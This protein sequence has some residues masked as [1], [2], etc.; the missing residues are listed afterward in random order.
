MMGIRDHE[1]EGFLDQCIKATGA[2]HSSDDVRAATARFRASLPEQKRS[3]ASRVM[4][5][6]GGAVTAALLITLVPQLLPGNGGAAF[7]QVQSWFENFRTVHATTVTRQGGEEISRIEVW[8]TAEGGMRLETGQSVQ[9]LDPSTGTF[10]TLLP[11]DRVMS[12]PIPVNDTSQAGGTMEWVESIREFQGDAERISQSRWIE[13]H[14]T[15]G[16]RL[17]VEQTT[18][19]LWAIPESGRPVLMELELGGGVTMETRLEFDQPLPEDAF[20]VPSHFHPI[21]EHG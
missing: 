9:I 18:V 11:G 14:E 12:M 7:A 8:A 16:Y 10:H 13:G 1:N 6:A 5:W 3:A 21:D 4:R 17:T 15:V 20:T 2:S 19:D